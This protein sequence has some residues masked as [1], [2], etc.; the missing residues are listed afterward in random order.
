M[1][2]GVTCSDF[3]S[4]NPSDE[5][6]DATYGI[7][8]GKVNNVAPGVMFY[9]IS[10]TAPSA[11][12]T[13]NVTQTNDAGM[14]ADP[15]SSE[16]PG[17][18]VQRPE[19]HEAQDRVVQLDDRDFD[20][21]GHRSDCR[22]DHVRRRG[23]VQPER[24]RWPACHCARPGRDVQLRHELQRW[25][26]I[27]PPVRTPSRCLRSPRRTRRGLI[28]TDGRPGN[29]PSHQLRDMIVQSVVARRGGGS[30]R[31]SATLTEATANAG[32]SVTYSVFSNSSAAKGGQNVEVEI[33]G[34]SR[35]AR[36]ARARGE[37][38]RRG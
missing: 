24:P 12:F 20:D 13:V 32:G 38:G 19:L 9:Y 4:N 14:E 1:H 5:L 26:R 7:K 34:H 28:Y 8:S 31:D 36:G 2:T 16:Q 18:P 6:T 30:V 3:L 21:Y 22:C 11:N 33:R 27:S 23:E 10:I 17:H 37:R 35:W 29:G 15:G 25:E